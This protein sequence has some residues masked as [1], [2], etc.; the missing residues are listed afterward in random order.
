MRT[1]LNHHHDFEIKQLL[2]EDIKAGKTL[3]DIK[4][5]YNVSASFI[6]NALYEYGIRYKEILDDRKKKL[7]E[8]NFSR[9]YD[10]Y[11]Q[12]GHLPSIEC[13]KKVLINGEKPT[14]YLQLLRQHL[15]LNGVKKQTDTDTDTKLRAAN[16]K[17]LIEDLHNIGFKLGRLPLVREIKK[18]SVYHPKDYINFFGSFKSALEEAGLE[19]LIREN[20]RTK[21]LEE[22]REELID[23]LAEKIR[24]NGHHT[25]KKEMDLD[26]VHN[27]SEYYR[28]FGSLKESIRIA[29]QKNGLN[30]KKQTIKPKRKPN[31]YY[32]PE[33]LIQHLLDLASRLG[34]SPHIYDLKKENK[35]SHVVYHK[36]FGSWKKALVTAGLIPQTVLDANLPV[37][38]VK[39]LKWVTEYAKANNVF[40]KRTEIMKE[41]EIKN[42]TFYKLFGSYKNLLYMAG[43]GR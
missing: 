33:N 27:Y 32:A 24:V 14:K 31:P 3:S 10:L 22:K 20:S 30:F 28:A 8:E 1:T 42:K 16:A 15:H 39:I 6:Y 18:H 4:E 2:A 26:A 12:L 9:C 23:Y 37:N 19:K 7:T 36:R 25:T 29:E 13:I 41:F 38:R 35:Y 11:I 21:R 40:P 5:K 34:R 17:E 43:Q